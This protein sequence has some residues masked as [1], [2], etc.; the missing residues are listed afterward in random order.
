MIAL[1]VL[2]TLQVNY[3]KPTLAGMFLD[4]HSVYAAESAQPQAFDRTPSADMIF[5]LEAAKPDDP[6]NVS[7]FQK[8]N[9]PPAIEDEEVEVSRQP[10]S[11]SQVD[12]LFVKAYE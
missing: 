6:T 7:A 1:C 3:S 10:L 9:M 2:L 11:K 12:K 5:Q 8:S 4:M